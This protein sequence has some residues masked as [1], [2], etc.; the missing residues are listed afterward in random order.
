MMYFQ[1]FCF[2]ASSI[3]FNPYVF[4]L[5]GNHL[6]LKFIICLGSTNKNSFPIGE[7]CSP[8]I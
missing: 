3:S 5:F 4:F 2:N 1:F 8:K 7:T 6:S